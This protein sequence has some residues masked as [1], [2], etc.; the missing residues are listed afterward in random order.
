MP[1]ITIATFNCENLFRRFKFSNKMT[2]E[3]VEHAVENGFIVNRSK[4]EV[5]PV[6]ERKLTAKMIKDTK[7][8]VVA[9][10]EV[11]NLDTLKNF[12]SENNLSSLYPYKLVIDGNDPRLIDVAVLSKIPF[13]RIMTHQYTKGANKRWLFS[14]DCLELE[15]EIENKPFFLFVNHLKSMF[16]RA[17]PV[18]GRKNTAAKRI[19][20]VD[21]VL[22]IIQDRL[23]RRTSTAAFAVVGDFN[24]YPSA[25]C[26]LIK[27]F[28]TK[29]LYNVVDNLALAER[30]T[31][32]WHNTK[33]KE[34]ER[35][36]QLDYIW[37]SKAL[38][39]ANPNVQAVIN[40]RGLSKKAKHHLIK[41]RYPEITSTT[42]DV[43][44]S[45]HCSVAVTLN[46]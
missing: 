2:P 33:L 31:H 1:S 23:K 17:D 43:A 4:F 9:L 38:V 32:Y 37:I 30:W 18:N 19:E 26:S 7:A 12:C 28:K 22:K 39:K 27:M 25:D 35:Y 11:E 41:K 21:G 13:S 20:Q 29:W 42:K 45:D 34:E 6:P 46:F 10:Q 40:R 3:Q 8:D 16:D 15:F 14:R 24:D 36:K 5:V 44:A